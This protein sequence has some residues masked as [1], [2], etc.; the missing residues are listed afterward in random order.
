MTT[1][2][3]QVVGDNS[4]TIRQVV[5]S[6]DRGPQGEQGIPGG[7][8]QY[9]AGAGINI[10]DDNKIS[11]TGKTSVAWGL[12]DGTLSDQTDLQTALNAKANTS[13]IPTVNN[14]TLT[15]Q[16]NGSTVGTFTANSSTNVTANIV[17]PV[18]IGSTLPNSTVQLSN[19]S[20]N[21]I[22]P[23]SNSLVA[24]T[25]T[26]NAIQDGAVT[27]AKLDASA[28]PTDNY[29][30]TEVATGYTW[31]DGNAIYKKTIN[32]GNLPNASAKTIAHDISGIDFIVKIEGIAYR[33]GDTSYFQLGNVP[34][35]S[36]SLNTAINVIANATSVVIT[37]GTD[38]SD[39]VA[40]VTLYYT[41][42]S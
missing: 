23:V 20:G 24:G 41:K 7:T 18:N 10:S 9:S 1:I 36:V 3:K 25:V 6:N 32:F 37:S 8:I 13:A 5:T 26:T 12:I 2:I 15:I 27:A 34:N 4:T 33:A 38:R 28:F 11:A 40:Y 29:S 17:S 14:A 39:T 35:P 22:Y 16:N 30:T 31:I 42:T 19:A 21:S